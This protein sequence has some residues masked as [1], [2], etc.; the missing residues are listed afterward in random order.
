VVLYALLMEPA[1]NDVVV[2]VNGGTAITMLRALVAVKA[3]VLASATCTVKFEV[4]A[5]VGV[6]E[7][8][9]VELASVSPAGNVPAV[10][11]HVYGEMPPAAVRV[12]AV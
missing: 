4:P 6:P 8:A 2:I 12:V 3:G 10:T 5:A 7:I 1:G 11:L 9:P